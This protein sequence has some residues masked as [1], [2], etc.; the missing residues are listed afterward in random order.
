MI[1]TSLLPYSYH[2]FLF[3]ISIEGEADTETLGKCGWTLDKEYHYDKNQYEDYNKWQYFFP[4]ARD[5]IFN[6]NNNQ[7]CNTYFKSF[8][9]SESRMNLIYNSGKECV[10]TLE[11]RIHKYKLTVWSEL[12]IA[13]LMI[14][15]NFKGLGDGRDFENALLINDIGRRL[16]PPALIQD[17]K[18]APHLVADRVTVGSKEFAIEAGLDLGIVKYILLEEKVDNFDFESIFDFASPILD[19]R[20]YVASLI[21]DDIVSKLFS[22]TLG[23][24]QVG[25]SSCDDNMNRIYEWAFAD[26]YGNCSCQNSV[27]RDDMLKTHIYSRWQNYGTIHAVT[28]YSFAC[29]TG[30]DV[31]NKYEVFSKVVLPFLA[32]YVEMAKLALAQRAA[33]VKLENDATELVN[34][35]GAIKI[36]DRNQSRKKYEVQRRAHDLWEKNIRFKDTLLMP[37]VTF[38][39]QGIELYDMLKSAL[40]IKDMSSY[41]EDEMASIYNYFAQEKSDR[42]NENLNFIT[43]VGTTLSVVSLFNEY[44]PA[45]GD[46]KFNKILSLPFYLEN[47]IGFVFIFTINAVAYYF[48]GKIMQCLNRK[49]SNMLFIFLMLA[50]WVF[51]FLYVGFVNGFPFYTG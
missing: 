1:D 18:P 33:L 32:E 20:M 41:V 21:R 47:I 22:D 40:R 9:P 11:L 35:M 26:Q 7:R 34:G 3:P 27:M 10:K 12:G 44:M 46:A 17:G 4:K 24:L 50:I 48:F 25:D 8:S 36:I 6:R 37:E 14:E 43:V 38:Q 16:F 45:S 30:E 49:K 19:D 31:G 23:K 51:A 2:T 28:E 13:V 5:S 29:L 39:Q 42:T 15:T